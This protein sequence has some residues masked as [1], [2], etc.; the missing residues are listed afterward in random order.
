MKAIVQ[1]TYGPPDV[2]QLRDIDRPAIGDEDVTYPLAEAPD[3][4]R[5]LRDGHP[6]GKIVLTV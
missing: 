6:A 4:I 3:A 2:L 5:H 1:D